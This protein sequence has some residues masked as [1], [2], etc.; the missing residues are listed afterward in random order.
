MI[1][2]ETL[3]ERRLDSVRGIAALCVAAGHCVT[4]RSTDPQYGKTFLTLDY[5]DPTAV[6]LR[7]LH[8]VFNAEAAILVFFVLSGYVLTTSLRNMGGGVLG[9][10]AAFGIKRVY[11]IFPAV[12]VSFLPLAFFIALPAIDYVRNMLLLESTINGVTWTLQVELAGSLLI[13][14]TVLMT[15]R[16][17]YLLF[18]LLALLGI[19]FL[20][21]YEWVFFRHLPA[22]FLGCFVGEI[23]KRL[24]MHGLLAPLS[25]LALATADFFFPYGSKPTVAVETVAAV[26]LI[27]TVGQSR[28]LR[29][30]DARPFVF[31]GRVSYSF[32]LYH[33]LGALLVLKAMEML[34]FALG[35]L[36]PVP[37]ALL[38]MVTSIPVAIV[39]ATLSYLLVERP[40]I[41]AGAQLARAVR[42]RLPG[43]AEPEEPAE[44]TSAAP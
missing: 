41:S 11:R 4:A 2:D 12:I 23:R 39:L 36:N 9:E 30:L 28:L 35:A 26:V 10:F 3:R 7:I 15:K 16:A 40:S 44:V 31:L 32:Y 43:A 8:L 22:F 34:G 29:F 14:L 25:V 24:P 27:A 6:V 18:P 13:F 37:G 5:G 38:Y 21:D 33:L 1:V 20:S 17:P 19:L 42:R